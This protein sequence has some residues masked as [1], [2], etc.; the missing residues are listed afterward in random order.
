MIFEALLATI[1]VSLISLVGIV[2]LILKLDQKFMDKFM[3][4]ILGFATGTMLAAT[5]FD[6]L[7][8]A[9]ETIGEKSLPIMLAGIFCFFILERLVHWHHG[10]HDHTEHE[11]PVG[12]LVLLGDGLHNFFDGIAIA[13]SFATAFPVGIATTAAIIFHEIPQELGDFALLKYAGFSDRKALLFNLASALSAVLG[14]IVFFALSDRIPNLAPYGLAFTAGAF[15]YIACTDMIP[16]LHREQH[17]LRAVA[18][19]CAVAV[20]ILFLWFL[21]GY[22]K[23]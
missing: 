4:I 11:K 23:A 12:W 10:H 19:V 1:T 3:L 5:F 7:P 21:Q 15:I 16:E 9:L 13:A 22:F 20:G 8:E 17:P 14:A 2:F 6:L 18:Q